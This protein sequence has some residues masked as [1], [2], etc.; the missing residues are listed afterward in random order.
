MGGLNRENPIRAAEWRDLAAAQP[1]FTTMTTA[2]ARV[3]SGIRRIACPPV[4]CWTG[5]PVP[6]FVNEDVIEVHYADAAVLHRMTQLAA[7]LN[8]K[9]VTHDDDPVDSTL[10]G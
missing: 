5:H 1:D 8:A 10:D 9:A 3:P 4:T 2:E 6:F 7:S